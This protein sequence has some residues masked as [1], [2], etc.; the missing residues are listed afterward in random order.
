MLST[1]THNSHT[2]PNLGYVE[3]TVPLLMMGG[4]MLH[5]I[6]VAQFLEFGEAH[7]ARYVLPLVDLVLAILMAYSSG[8]L[9]GL[10]RRFFQTYQMDGRWHKFVYYAVTFYVTASI[11]GHIYFLSTGDA[12]YF[13]F[14]PMW[15]SLFIMT[16]YIGV[17]V[18]FST[19]KIRHGLRATPN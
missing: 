18:F 9:I 6:R 5:L 19:L 8:C 16:I 10:R 15:F 7:V 11:P 17:I 2:A 12:S 13:T 14:F 3:M 4:F 1:T